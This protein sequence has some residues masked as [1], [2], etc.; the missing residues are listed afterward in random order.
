M[1]NT[2]RSLQMLSLMRGPTKRNMLFPLRAFSNQLATSQQGIRNGKSKVS[3]LWEHS[4][5]KL[6]EQAAKDNEEA[7]YLD[8]LKAAS[9][10]PGTYTPLDTS[11][12]SETQ[13]KLKKQINS[14]IAKEIEAIEFKEKVSQEALAAD[15][16]NEV[17]TRKNFFFQVDE[18]KKERNLKLFDMKAPGNKHRHPNVILPHEV[19]DVQNPIDVDGNDQEQMMDIYAH[20]SY[21]IDMHIAQVRPDNLDA[22]SYIPKRFNQLE[23]TTTCD[24]ELDNINFEYYHRWRE[25]TRTW[26]SQTQE[27]NFQEQLKNRPTTTHYDHDKG[28]QF[29]IEWRDDQKFPHVADRLGYPILREEPI[30]RILGIE[31][32]PAHPGYQFQPF[33]QTPSMDPDPTLDFKQGETIYENSRVVEWTR[34]WK[35]SIACTFGFA[36]GFYLFETYAGDGM[37]SLSWAG[38]NF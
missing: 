37:P 21:L 23:N 13:S 25:P 7:A 17:I 1:I 36:P 9:T 29:E 15:T 27:I 8:T 24:P 2:S 10:T 12:A 34:F 5:Q 20:Y 19:F 16:Y 28:S 6:Q 18:Q 3:T 14:I 38:E 4:A 11:A 31:R 22:K 33:V 30:E 35:T 26:F 32:S